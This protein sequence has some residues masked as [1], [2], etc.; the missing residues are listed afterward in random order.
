M[1]VL[2]ESEKVHWSRHILNNGLIFSATYHGVRHIPLGLSYGIG[3]IGTWLAY[4]LMHE[5]STAVR[6]N[7]R[8]AFPDRRETEIRDLTL[9]TLRSYARDTIDLIR[10][11]TASRN[12]LAPSVAR[13]DRRPF[14][15]LLDKGKGVLL[16]GAHLGNWE[17]GGVLLR[18]FYDYPITVVA[19]A[20]PSPGINRRRKA[21]RRFLGVDTLE[22]RKSM[23][24]PLQ[25]LRLLS[26]NR[27]VAMLLDRHLGRDRI[28]VKM[29][30]RRAFFLRTPALMSSLSGAPLLPAVLVREDDG[31]FSGV[32]GEPIYVERS[33]DR[34]R[35]LQRAS[36]AYATFLEKQ[37]RLYPHLWYHFYPYWAA[38]KDE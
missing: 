33:G 15:S 12:E 4:H 29:L 32:T 30:D 27:I 34:E 16:A 19:M 25:I 3:K 9:L 6:D 11:F 20:E 2:R 35:A 7:L 28:E 18:K 37:V 26:E 21:I 22:V 24:T 17:L 10:S 36:Q 13:F 14:D 23:D 1:A 38:P 8:T 5:L 31:R